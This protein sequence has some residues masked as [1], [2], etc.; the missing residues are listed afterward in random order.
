MHVHL[1]G[2]SAFPGWARRAHPEPADEMA[3]VVGSHDCG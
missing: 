3:F 2:A 1:N